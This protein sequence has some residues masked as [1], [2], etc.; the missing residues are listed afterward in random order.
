MK[1]QAT[2]EPQDINKLLEQI[3]KNRIQETINEIYHS[4]HI[5]ISF[6]NEYNSD[7]TEIFYLY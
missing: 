4:N 3:Q 2:K 5:D 7:D 1:T 6:I